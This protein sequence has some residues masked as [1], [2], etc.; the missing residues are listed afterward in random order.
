MKPTKKLLF[1]FLSLLFHLSSLQ[2]QQTKPNILLIIADDM[3]I[4][5]TNGYQQNPRM[6]TT[7]V[8]DSLRT[9]GLTFMNT[10]ASPQ[11]TPTRASIM[12]GKYG[13]K[14][15]V[16]TP[17]GNL[18][19]T[20]KSLFS[21]LAEDHQNEYTGAVIGK[22]HIS[23]PIDYNHPMQHG[24]DHY[25]GLFSAFVDDYYSWDK[26]VDGILTTSNEYVTTDLTDAAIDWVDVQN[27]PW[28][29]SS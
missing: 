29:F 10:W 23:N 3:G 19:L 4:D 6:P 7:P 20:H 13:I 12:S 21:R 5:V 24:I 22:W 26:V 28:F 16:M 25:E 9:N 27:Q 18:D 17:P 2:S 11:C 1:F 8:L 14:T 15:G